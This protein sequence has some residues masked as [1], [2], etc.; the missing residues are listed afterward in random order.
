[1]V[2]VPH[3]RTG[4]RA[5]AAVVSTNDALAL[6]DLQG[7]LRDAGLATQKWPEDLRLVAELPRTASGKVPKFLL[8]EAFQASC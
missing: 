3:A 6:S 8:R 4:E 5:C 7:F 2:A 1:M